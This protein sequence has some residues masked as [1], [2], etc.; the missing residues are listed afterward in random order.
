MRIIEAKLELVFVVEGLHKS[1]SFTVH[2]QRFIHYPIPHPDQPVQNKF[3]EHSG[4][5]NSSLQ[6]ID[7]LYHVRKRNGEYEI[8]DSWLG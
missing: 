7:T 2:V 3:L 6:Q 1:K 4:Y 5:L 8:C